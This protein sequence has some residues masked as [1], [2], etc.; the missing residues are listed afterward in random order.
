MLL[1]EP[2]KSKLVSEGLL[3]AGGETIA[4]SKL[5]H[6]SPSPNA[7]RG[8]AQEREQRGNDTLRMR[9]GGVDPLDVST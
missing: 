2:L 1:C 9:A 8:T 3:I 5:R 6:E 7:V 4:V